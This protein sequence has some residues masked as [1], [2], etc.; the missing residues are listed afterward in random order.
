ME[1][2]DI[3]RIV[4]AG[5]IF[6]LFIF[7]IINGYFNDKKARKE[8]FENYQEYSAYLEEQEARENAKNIVIYTSGTIKDGSFLT[9]K[10]IDN[11]FTIK[12]K[13]DETYNYHT[14]R[15]AYRID[16][17]KTNIIDT[18]ILYDYYKLIIKDGNKIDNTMTS[19]KEI[20]LNSITE[21]INSYGDNDILII[22]P[23]YVMSKEVTDN[24][25]KDGLLY[26]DVINAVIKGCKK[27]N[28]KYINLYEYTKDNPINNE[29]VYE[30]YSKEL[31]SYLLDEI[32]KN[33]K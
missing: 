3:K 20:A 6:A 18:S 12:V 17:T 21:F 23:N 9:E 25:K 2:R 19:G 7:I 10:L 15:Y 4:Y 16:K 30:E 8:G 24:I 28:K 14:S 22:S 32:L 31:Q 1:P 11:G 26:E 27:Y 33:T 13:T 29:N 5:M